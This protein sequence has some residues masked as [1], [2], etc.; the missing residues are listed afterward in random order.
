MTTVRITP[1][2]KR[3][4]AQFNQFTANGSHP[5]P[6]DEAWKQFQVQPRVVN[7]CR[8]NG[9]LAESGIKNNYVVTREAKRLANIVEEMIDKTIV[10]R[11]VR[12]RSSAI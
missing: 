9:L 1:A 4:L 2:R 7:Y 8:R 10:R 3:F 11:R 6:I 5:H 12:K